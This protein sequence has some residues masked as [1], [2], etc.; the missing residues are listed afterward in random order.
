MLLSD[1]LFEPLKGFFDNLSFA[2]DFAELFS[3]FGISCADHDLRTFKARLLMLTILPIA[4][5]LCIAAVFMFR[6]LSS[7]PSRMRALRRGHSTLVLLLLY[8]TLPSTSTMVF[9][10]FVRDSRPLGTN[11]EQYLIADYAGK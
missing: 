1:V 8:L 4:L 11:G 6:V 7:H 2:T 3:G 9:K 10:A 5:G